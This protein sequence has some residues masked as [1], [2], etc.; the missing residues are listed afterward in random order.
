MV[1]SAG[2]EDLRGKSPGMLEEEIKMVGLRIYS[3][4]TRKN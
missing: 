1:R 3:D 2:A 4:P